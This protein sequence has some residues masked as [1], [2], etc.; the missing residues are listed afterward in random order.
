LSEEPRP[1]DVAAGRKLSSRKKRYP[2]EQVL[3]VR[4]RVWSGTRQAFLKRKKKGPKLIR[5]VRT[6]V[7][8][9]NQA[10]NRGEERKRKVCFRKKKP[11][12]EG[13]PAY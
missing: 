4:R 5:A 11:L 3:A 13:E 8:R 2:S 1:R 10:G 9:E 7:K 12:P 6:K